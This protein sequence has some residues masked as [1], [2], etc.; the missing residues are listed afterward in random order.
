MCGSDSW[1][2]FTL[3][4]RP[5]SSLSRGS[6]LMLAQIKESFTERRSNKSFRSRV[7][8]LGASHS[9]TFPAPLARQP[10]FRSFFVFVCDSRGLVEGV[11][12]ISSWGELRAKSFT[13]LTIRSLEENKSFAAVMNKS[14]TNDE[15]LI[16]IKQSNSGFCC[17]EAII[18][19]ILLL[20][21]IISKN[22]E[23]K[24]CIR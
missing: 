4:M 7:S 2:S 23:T 18:S 24:L 3:V 15:S 20:W 8:L 9:R 21:R 5:T 13:R 1:Q 14:F 10:F 12:Y 22:T 11:C 19:N 17:L 6:S 16:H